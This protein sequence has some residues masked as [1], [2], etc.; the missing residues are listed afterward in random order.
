MALHKLTL[1][2]DGGVGKTALVHQICMQRFLETYDPTIEDSYRKQI[3]VDGQNCMLE[4][5]DTAG[6]EEY[7][8]L[9]DQWIRTSEAIVIVYSISSRSSF[10]RVK[11][12]HRQIQRIR[13]H[14]T[15]IC[16]I[17]NKSDRVTE[18]EVST[19]EG[20]ELALNL[21]I[22]LFVEC[23]AKNAINIEKAFYDLVRS[24]RAQKSG[25]EGL[26]ERKQT[27]LGT[28][29]VIPEREN[30]TSLGR[31]KLARALVHA[32]RTNNLTDTYELLDAGADINA[33]PSISG[34]ALHEAASLGYLTMVNT[35]LKQGAGIN[36]KAPSGVPPL[37]G[38]AAGGHLDVVKLLIQQGANRDQT[39]GVRGT[40]LHAAAMRGHAKVVKYLL[41]QGANPNTKA[42]PYEFALHAA[43]WFGAADTV[44]AL[45]DEGAEIGQ[46]TEEGCTALHM[47]AFTG[48]VRVLQSLINRGGKLHINVVSTRFGTALDAADNS[49]HFAA[50]QL[51][52]DEKAK[53]SGL[54]L[55]K[56]NNRPNLLGPPETNRQNGSSNPDVNDGQNDEMSD[57]EDD[58]QQI[59][60][61]SQSP[62]L[63]NHIPN[64]K[65]LTS[66]SGY[67]FANE[68]RTPIPPRPPIQNL[69]F[70]TLHNPPE[71]RSDIVF[72]HGLQGHPEKTWTFKNEP[73]NVPLTWREKLLRQR[74]IKRAVGT[75][76][77][78]PYDLLCQHVEFMSSRVMTWG[79]DTKVMREFLGGS[80]KRGEI[81]LGG[82][83][84][85]TALAISKNSQYQ[86]QYLPVYSSLLGIVFLA[87]PHNGSGTA[88]WGLIASNLAKFALQRP[89]TSVLRGLKPNNEV[90]VNLQRTF[91]Q[92]LED[93][94]F[95][96]HSFWETV[97]MSGIKGLK[98]LVVP[99]ESATVG[100][101]KKEI[102]LGITATHASIC[103]FSGPSDPGYQ[104]VFGALQDYIRASAHAK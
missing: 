45:L 60:E 102:C 95:T 87:T 10:S 5:L 63:N 13:S 58:N 59:E 54:Q 93:G 80:S 26:Y 28:Q 64:G 99:Y 90:L 14:P 82:I 71:A 67:D 57:N 8:A 30:E 79:Y 73:E 61:Q 56:W 16:L 84:V 65:A 46:L 6:Q 39:S 41:K 52:R 85:K 83:I 36:A 101:A 25:I 15:P 100:H 68:L 18:R 20:F 76:V 4:I 92:M 38:A 104:A 40:A 51:L 17:G 81:I 22:E 96:I 37:Q 50:V 97:P 27:I 19:T 48:N 29:L 24:L 21:G 98:G 34:S 31:D 43:S 33:Q 12:F 9:R 66:E 74:R 86:P 55:S 89:S 2:G 103:K 91:L 53:K 77:Y 94:H 78:W 23:S 1:L 7:T 70:T 42:G 35:L 69:G 32:A 11:R 47:A 62:T 44:N 3:P 75:T 72:V 88:G 49:G